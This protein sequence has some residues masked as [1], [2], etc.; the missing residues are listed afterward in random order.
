M[1][2]DLV[3]VQFDSAVDVRE[4]ELTDA[5]LA[6]KQTDIN[7]FV[8]RPRAPLAPGETRTLTFTT[9]AE[10][11]RFEG[12]D[13]S[14]FVE[15]NGTFL[16]T[17]D[18][19]PSIGVLRSVFLKD[20]RR[21]RAHGLG[22]LDHTPAPDDRSQYDRNAIRGDSDFVRFA[23]TVSTSPD[24]TAIAPGYL[25]REWVENGRRHF[26]YEMDKPILNF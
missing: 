21:R 18:L 4:V 1:P 22:P 2:I 20:E 6:D 25:E 16:S 14:S 12:G 13:E 10:R 8:F 15:H 7:H 17:A 5:D 26:R 11:A 23:I 24:Q 9:S 3:R 19:A